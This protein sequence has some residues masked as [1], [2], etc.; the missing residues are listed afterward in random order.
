MKKIV[1]KN[2]KEVEKYRQSLFKAKAAYRREQAELP[3][4]EKIA[5]VM[6]LNRFA[7]EWGA[8][9]RL[10]GAPETIPA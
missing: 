2:E 8:A 5:I 4:E 3:F 9:S 1:A 10:G 7:R 6:K